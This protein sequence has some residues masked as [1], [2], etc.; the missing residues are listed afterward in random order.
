MLAAGSERGKVVEL[1]KGQ[2]K[3]KRQDGGATK[4]D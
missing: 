3:L 4:G 1:K 2:K